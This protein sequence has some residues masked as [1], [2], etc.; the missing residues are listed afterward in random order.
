MT[1]PI[2]KYRAQRTWNSTP[3]DL[4]HHKQLSAMLTDQ[5]RAQAEQ[6]ASEAGLDPKRQMSVI[7]AAGIAALASAP[8]RESFISTAKAGREKVAAQDTEPTE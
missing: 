4:R 5:E 8:N 2:E 7:V 1:D 3:R 6:L